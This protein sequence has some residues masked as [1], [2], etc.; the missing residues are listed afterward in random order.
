MKG[1]DVHRIQLPVLFSQ[2]R[3]RWFRQ[4]GPLLARMVRA[5]AYESRAP[6]VPPTHLSHPEPKTCL[7][8]SWAMA[9]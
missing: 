6:A 7:R 2:P 4:A 1:M 3:P 9:R 8:S 5:V